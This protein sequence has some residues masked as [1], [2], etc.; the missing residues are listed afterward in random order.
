MSAPREKPQPERRGYRILDWC[1]A[2][3][4]SPAMA[5]KMM[6][7]GRLRYVVI[8]GRRW[9]SNEEAERLHRDGE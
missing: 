8:G 3:D 1:A 2:Y 7:D 9:I 4:T 5:Y 6:N